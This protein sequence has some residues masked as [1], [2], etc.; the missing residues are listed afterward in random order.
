M[1]GV[2]PTRFILS[3]GQ[4]ITPDTCIAQTHQEQASATT[5][6]VADG[7]SIVDHVIRQPASISLTTIWTPRPDDDSYEPRGTGRPQDAFD[8]LVSAL[9]KRQPIQIEL[10]N[11]TYD[12]VVLTSVSMPRAFADGDG[13][14][15][16]VEAQEIQIVRGQTVKIKVAPALKSKGKKSKKKVELPPSRNNAGEYAIGQY[17]YRAD[18]P[19]LWNAPTDIPGPIDF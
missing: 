19:N 7:S 14:T 18:I 16:E 2:L 4:V 5:H 10:D 15:I 8:I 9:K 11:I 17:I 3:D 6:P 1:N 13:R 12:P